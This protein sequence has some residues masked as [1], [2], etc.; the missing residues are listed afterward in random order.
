[1]EPVDPFCQSN[2]KTQRLSPN[3][4]I[5]GKVAITFTPFTLPF[6]SQLKAQEK[7]KL[8]GKEGFVKNSFNELINVKEKSIFEKQLK[9]SKLVEV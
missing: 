4:E 2:P 3:S 7:D 1:M 9:L 8:G 5:V 6:F